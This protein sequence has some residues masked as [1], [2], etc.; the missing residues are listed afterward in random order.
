MSEINNIF[1]YFYNCTTY[2]FLIWIAT[3]IY[4]IGPLD[5]TYPF[6][7]SGLLQKVKWATL[8]CSKL[9]AIKLRYDMNN[10]VQSINLLTRLEWK[11][12]KEHEKGNQGIVTKSTKPYTVSWFSFKHDIP[13]CCYGLYAEYN[14]MRNNMHTIFY[15]TPHNT[16]WPKSGDRKVF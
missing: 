16:V 4:E 1:N 5:V 15:E 8:C 13:L 11:W 14:L 10:L 6:T 7:N 2:T 12:K 3:H 9:S